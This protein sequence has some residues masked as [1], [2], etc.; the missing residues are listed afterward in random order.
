MNMPSDP[1]SR[2]MM[3]EKLKVILQVIHEV[4]DIATE[5]RDQARATNGRVT[6][7]ETEY[8][9]RRDIIPL[10][11]WSTYSKGAVA[12]LVAIVLP[13]LGFLSYQVV[14]HLN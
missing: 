9:T 7:I 1:Y 3:D 2:E 6:K 4:K 5:T 12:V 10:Y 13:I 8:V 11:Q 14:T